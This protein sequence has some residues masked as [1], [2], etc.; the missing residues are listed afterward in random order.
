[1]IKTDHSSRGDQY[2][3]SVLE[4][5]VR[6]IDLMDRLREN[7][8]E[9]GN[10]CWVWQGYCNPSGHG[11]LHSSRRE[12]RVKLLSHRAMWVVANGFLPLKGNVIRHRCPGGANSG[13]IRPIH[14]AQGKQHD[15]MRDA[16]EEGALPFTP[17]P[18]KVIE[19]LAGRV[20]NRTRRTGE[21][22][23]IAARLG[24]PRTCLSQKVSR[25]RKGN[26]VFVPSECGDIN[27]LESVT[28]EN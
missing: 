15:N 19:Y 2:L 25:H 1:M 13:C 3:A 24:I 6:R 14:L 16:A 23:R 7:T 27:S 10:G 12:G 26:V 4:D 20:D 18:L 11:Q 22:Q 28:K 17:V 8:V 5:W 9:D 21:F